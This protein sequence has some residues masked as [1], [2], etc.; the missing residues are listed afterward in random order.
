MKMQHTYTK[1]SSIIYKDICLSEDR[2]RTYLGRCLW[3]EMGWMEWEQRWR[4]RRVAP[5][6]G[7]DGIC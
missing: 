4:G 6:T 3:E 1:Q 5:V 2:E 7:P